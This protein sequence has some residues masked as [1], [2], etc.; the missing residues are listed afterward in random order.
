MDLKNIEQAIINKK[1]IEFYYDR[2][3]RI[4]EPHLLGTTKAGNLA[5]RAIK[6]EDILIQKSHHGNC[7]ELKR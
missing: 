1:V 3:L 4:V 5:L 7:F 6:L 2:M